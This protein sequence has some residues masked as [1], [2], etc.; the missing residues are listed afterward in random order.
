[1][2]NKAIRRLQLKVKKCSWP[3]P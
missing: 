1:M 2:P 3:C